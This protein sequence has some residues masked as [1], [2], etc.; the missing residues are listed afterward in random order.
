[1]LFELEAE[2]ETW[3][4]LVLALCKTSFLG[5]VSFCHASIS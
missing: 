3:L 5:T 4:S 1:M 2:S